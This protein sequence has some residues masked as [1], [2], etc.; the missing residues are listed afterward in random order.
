M[1]IQVEVNLRIPNVKN[2]IKDSSGYPISSS[3]VRFIKSIEVSALPKPGESIELSTTH[4][5]QFNAKIVRV[6]WHEDKAS[7]V[8]ACTF[9]NRSI[10]PEEYM[11]LIQ[12]PDWIMKPLL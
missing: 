2:P 5:F 1:S 8:I 11:S 6:N 7:F 4:G 10:K 9:A 3:D 12:D